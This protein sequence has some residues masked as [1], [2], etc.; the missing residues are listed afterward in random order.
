MNLTAA[1]AG[2]SL[3]TTPV[4]DQRAARDASKHPPLARS[5]LAWRRDLT[6]NYQLYLLVLLPVAY[7]FVFMYIPMYG[8]QIAFRNF[9]AVKGIWGSE[10][11]GVK[12][13][14]K[15]FDSPYFV[16]VVRNTLEISLY[17]LIAGFPFPILLAV[18]L[19]CSLN[20]RF[21]KTVQMVTYAPYFISTVVMVGML[22]QFLSPR[23]GFVNDIIAAIGFERVRFLSEPALFSSVYVWSG[24]WQLTGWNSIIYLAALSTVD[25]ELHEAAIV[26]GANRFR[27]ILHIDIPSILPTIVVLLIIQCGQIMTVG[28]EKVFLMQVPLNLSRSEI[29]ATYVY[30]VGLVSTF[31]DYSYGAAIGLFNALIN[32]VLI[33]A[34]NRLAR[35][36]TGQSLW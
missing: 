5:L 18:A 27:R 26:D 30:K 1:P 25:P 35:T 21:K 28:F 11:V 10:W 8:T 7:I 19:N 6:V 15:F 23:I 33:L 14:L 32:L 20:R 2:A 12:Y 34:V 16:R 17:T 31:P 9:L 22:I 29:I 36:I 3:S 24:V 4:S 13:F